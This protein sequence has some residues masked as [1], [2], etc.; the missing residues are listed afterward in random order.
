MRWSRHSAPALSCCGALLALL[1]I[2]PALGCPSEA[3]AASQERTAPGDEAAALVEA[4]IVALER[5][6]AATARA[7]FRRALELDRD[8]VGAHTYLGLIADREG[9]LTE[10]ERHFA[11]AAA[12]APLSPQARNNHGAI[13]LRLGRL[14]QA[15]AQ[16]EISLR[17]DRNQPSPLVNLA[18]I[19][20]D[21][22]RPEELKQALELFERAYALA[23]EVDIAR[24]LVATTLRLGDRERAAR[25]FREYAALLTGTNA[26]PA[27]ARAE[28]GAALSAAGLLAE[29]IA[30]LG[31]AVAA[32]PDNLDALLLLARAHLRRGEIPAAGRAL[33]AAVARGR[34]DARLYAALAE[35]YEAGGYFEN[36]IPAMRLA[37]ARDPGNESYHVRYGLLLTDTKA[38]AAAVIR[39][40]E[41][42]T[43]F[44][45]S[46]RLWLALGIAQL[47]DGKNEDAQQSFARVLEL[48]RRSV[49]A[50]AYLGTVHAERGQ[51]A[52]AV[53][54]YERAI[55]ADPQG[56]VPYYLAADALLKFAEVDTA[57]VEKYLARAVELDPDF[58]S[59]RLALGR[60]YV[61]RE[62]WDE[63]AKQL[64]Q[65]V[66]LAPQL[67]DARYQ[68]GR[69]YVR[70]KRQEEAKRELD[71]FQE[72]S[73]TQK[74]KR[75]SDRRELIRRL[76]D[77]KF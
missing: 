65:A 29:A 38:P 67:A 52:E 25:Y 43:Q 4:G 46:P 57:R 70:L 13:L 32:A 56:P 41:A 37:I 19:R 17:L 1:F 8:H 6:D 54:Y 7:S 16:F 71:A 10:A 58:A 51:L 60:L 44:P 48:D 34:E 3:R 49:P 35:V 40:R 24:S 21:G 5:G 30:E 53:A 39:L 69:V 12:A 75:E 20:F 64:E 55:A 11:A 68:L 73:R 76:A 14:K 18:Q 77:V 74:E 66:R 22:G 26:P 47:N 9:N 36:A 42:L 62:Q 31:A 72:L 33:E 15:A 61:R 28:L 45:G 50:L 2:V 23:P 27:A 63:A 59:A